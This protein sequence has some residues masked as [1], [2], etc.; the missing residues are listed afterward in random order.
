VKLTTHLNPVLRLRLSG[1]I[2]VFPL[3]VFVAGRGTTTLWCVICEF[4]ISVLFIYMAEMLTSIHLYVCVC[5]F[6]RNAAICMMV[7]E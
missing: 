3:D 4:H 1:A 5:F 7:S 2:H 6:F